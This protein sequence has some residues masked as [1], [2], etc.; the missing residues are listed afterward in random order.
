MEE[1]GRLDSG[2]YMLLYDGPVPHRPR[3]VQLNLLFS[4]AERR[5]KRGIRVH[6]GT[7]WPF[8]EA[9]RAAGSSVS[10]LHLFG[11]GQNGARDRQMPIFPELSEQDVEVPGRE[12][13][14]CSGLL[15][16]SEVR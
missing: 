11:G 16:V 4:T 1:E 2:S 15:H 9:S 14:P 3:H 13:D 6:I 12:R 8:S 7:T 10:L 5:Q